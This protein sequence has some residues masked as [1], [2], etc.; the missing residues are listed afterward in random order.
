MAISITL[1]TTLREQVPG[2][3]P[4]NGLCRELP[5]PPTP[6]ALAEEL[7]LPLAAIKLVMRN[8]RRVDLD[9]IL[10]DGDRVAY[11]PAI[12]GG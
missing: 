8:G 5:Q 11:F 10:T 4:Q 9:A 7:R 6:A 1:S 12:G 3:D 2:Y